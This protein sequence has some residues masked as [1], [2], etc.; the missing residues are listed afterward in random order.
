MAIHEVVA[1]KGV[2]HFDA[3]R[4]D[5]LLEAAGV[6]AFV[7]TSRHNVRYLADG[8]SLYFSHNWALA[9]DRYLQAAACVRGRLDQAFLVASP[10]EADEFA[11][12]PPWF[13]TVE[14]AGYSTVDTARAVARLF[15]ERGLEQ[16]TLG[17]EE[18]FV[19]YRFQHE[20][21]RA[22]PLA[23]FVDVTPLLGKQRMVKRPA[24][25][26]L[27]RSA[28]ERTVDAMHATMTGMPAGSTTL[29]IHNRL[30]TEELERGLTFEFLAMATGTDTARMPTA[31]QR[32]EPGAILSMDSGGSLE[33]YPADVTR[34]AVLGEPTPRMRECLDQCLA[35][36]DAV[37]AVL[38][39]GVTGREVLAAVVDT[40]RDLPDAKA[41]SPENAD[42]ASYHRSIN[43][44]MH[45]VGVVRHETPRIDFGGPVTEDPPLLDDGLEAGTA[46]AIDMILPTPD[47]GLVKLEEVVAVT[48]DGYEAYGDRHRDWTVV[49]D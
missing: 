11:V 37:R 49:G 44:N 30:V 23:T 38:R 35:I 39:P 25:L 29:D 10:Q 14:L 26:E 31:D 4:L 16:A 48:A 20:L 7:A 13:P 15:K 3:T 32:W 46:L 17:I 27:V 41:L 19:P 45:G 42:S 5:R 9:E 6:D 40:A 8:Y 21:S 24:E 47:V 34:M 22:L 33:G 43:F 12:V 28:T 18:P 2:P 36:N 1:T